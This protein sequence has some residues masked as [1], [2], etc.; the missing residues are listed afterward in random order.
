MYGD[1]YSFVVMPIT[2]PDSLRCEI[3]TYFMETEE[4]VP[5]LAAA[6]FS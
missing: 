4:Q 2:M 1:E 3:G 6:L 5:G